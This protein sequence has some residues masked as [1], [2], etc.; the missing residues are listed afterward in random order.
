MVGKK[1]EIIYSHVIL[2]ESF[3][4]LARCSKRK[5]FLGMTVSLIPVR[6]VHTGHTMNPSGIT[7]HDFTLLAPE[8]TLVL[9]GFI[10][11]VLG[12]ISPRLYSEA[13]FGIVLIGL[14]V[15]L[16]FTAQH[17]GGQPAQAFYGMITV[18]KFTVGFQCLFIIAAGLTLMLSLNALEEKYLLYSEYFARSSCHRRNDVDGFEL[19]FVAFFSV[20]N[21]LGFF[22]RSRRFSPHRP[23]SPGSVLQIFLARRFRQRF[24]ALWHRV[25]LWQHR[26]R[27]FERIG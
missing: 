14:A 27:E 2:E 23:Q 18:D 15:S 11:L 16:I 20:G 6:L 17:W 9:V 5:K 25:D 4:V 22:V 10:V 1:F 19:A 21:A 12:L 13:L 26:Q 3:F 24:F 8:L 7:W